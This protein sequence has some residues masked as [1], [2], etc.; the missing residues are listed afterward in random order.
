MLPYT[1]TYIK[2]KY[3]KG[4]GAVLKKSKN[5]TDTLFPSPGYIISAKYGF[6][7]ARFMDFHTNETI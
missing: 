2:P 7:T 3:K 4:V 1:A 6:V 5:K